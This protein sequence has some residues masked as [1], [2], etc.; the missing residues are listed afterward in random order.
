MSSV[1]IKNIIAHYLDNINDVAF[2]EAIKTIMESKVEKAYYQ[3]SDQQKQR[4]REARAEYESGN[5]LPHKEVQDNI[6]QW[7]NSK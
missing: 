4:V 5:T 2:L 3:L 1:E 7:L 6:D